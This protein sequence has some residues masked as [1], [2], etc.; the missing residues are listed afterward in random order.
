M[1]APVGTKLDRYAVR[2]GRGDGGIPQVAAEAL[3]GATLLNGYAVHDDSTMPTAE[4]SKNVAPSEAASRNLGM[5]SPSPPLDGV[6][7][8]QFGP[9]ILYLSRYVLNLCMA[10]TYHQ[11]FLHVVFAASNR[12]AYIMDEWKSDFHGY[13]AGILKGRKHHPIAVG[14]VWDHVHILVG[15]HPSD[16]PSEMVKSIKI[17]STKWINDIHTPKCRPFSW[18]RGYGIF[19]YSKSHIETVKKYIENQEAH[20]TKVSMRDEFRSI[21]QKSGIEFEE[22]YILEDI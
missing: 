3:L 21:L 20:H 15:F 4:P 17:A 12:E 16:S 18:Q 6:A 22:Q 7:V 11:I 2:G 13:I 5:R 14:G 10:N 9:I 8:E 19:S 1:K